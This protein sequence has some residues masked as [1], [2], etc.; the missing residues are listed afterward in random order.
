MEHPNSNNAEGEG[1]CFFET[2]GSNYPT[3]RRNNP[4]DLVPQQSLD[5]NLNI[6]S[7]IFLTTVSSSFAVSCLCV[8]DLLLRTKDKS[9]LNIWTSVCTSTQVLLTGNVGNTEC[10]Y[11]HSEDMAVCQQD[12]GIA[13]HAPHDLADNTVSVQLICI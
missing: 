2:S 13:V 4:E 1:G 11:R 6:V 9:V 3:T 8:I 7:N 5:G 12:R 10:W